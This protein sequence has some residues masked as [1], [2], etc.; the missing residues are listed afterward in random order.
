MTA[1]GIA[2]Q[3]A[4]A[5]PGDV[6]LVRQGFT[7]WS[8][9]TDGEWRSTEITIGPEACLPGSDRPLT[10]VLFSYLDVVTGSPPPG[11][12]NP[13]VDLQVRLLA[14]P[15]LGRIRFRSRTLRLGRTF[16]VADAEMRQADEDEPFGVCL[17]TFMNAPVP[18]P[19][20]LEAGRRAGAGPGYGPLAGARRV[21]AG[22]F[23]IDANTDT[24][25]GTVGGAILGR[26]AELAAV[27]ALDGGVV[28]D[29]LDVRFLNKVKGDTLRATATVLRRGSGTTT[30]RVEVADPGRAGASVTYALVVCRD[31]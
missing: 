27:D 23:E 28:V 22:V 18:F 8:V 31:G 30:V 12:L 21:S 4:A 13:T 25:Q 15:R 11:P 10:G 14:P 19:G 20:R 6:S 17:A 16:Y 5:C 9:D 7:P 24:P 26:L 29:E 3:G 2:Q 1:D